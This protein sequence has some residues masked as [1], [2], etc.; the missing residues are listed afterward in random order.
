MMKCL[1][2]D[3]HTHTAE[4]PRDCIRYSS[5]DLIDAV[6]QEGLGVLAITCHEKLV[7]RE[8]LSDYARQ[9]GVLLIPGIELSVEGKHVLILNPDEAHLRAGSFAELRATGRRDAVFIAPHPFYP[10]WTSLNRAFLRHSDLFD[11]I[12][13]C[14]AYYWGLNFNR[15]AEK[16]S[17]DL[18]LPMVGTSDTHGLPY[19][20]STFTWVESEP[21]VAGVL[22][23][24]RAG[25]V[26][27]ETRP[28]RLVHAARTALS[29]AQS[30]VRDVLG[31]RKKGV[32][33]L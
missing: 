10:S 7:R 16:A 11:A 1:K 2:A 20:A 17:Q 14:N 26:T 33:S 30:T 5:E 22:G 28:C 24:I 31:V 9:R 3:F 15:R 19:Q 27:V 13:Y 12:E 18:G 21:T 29:S 25:R 8:G 32:S 23:A 6:A 4:D